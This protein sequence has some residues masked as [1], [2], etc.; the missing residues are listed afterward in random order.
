[1]HHDNTPDNHAR[2]SAPDARAPLRKVG[3]GWKPRP[4]SK[5]VMSGAVTINGLR[6]RFFVFPNDKKKAGS[7]EPDF[8][9]LSS[10]EPEVDTYAQQRESR[11]A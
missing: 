6:Q 1:M 2:E 3:S 9:L 8:L 5:A 11:S 7:K 4:G 10:E